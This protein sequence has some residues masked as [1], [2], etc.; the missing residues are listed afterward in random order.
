LEAH[1]DEAVL[2]VLRAPLMKFADADFFHLL[3]TLDCA[4]TELVSHTL[5]PMIEP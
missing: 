2:F 5:P 1:V 4:G 3:K